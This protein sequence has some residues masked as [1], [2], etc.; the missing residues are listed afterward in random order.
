MDSRRK[1]RRNIKLTWRR[2]H[3]AVRA[4]PG[5][6][7]KGCF[8]LPESLAAALNRNANLA[9]VEM[10][11]TH[12]VGSIA[13]TLERPSR[14]S[15]RPRAFSVRPSTEDTTGSDGE[16][17]VAEIQA[18]PPV[19]VLNDDLIRH[20]VELANEA[21]YRTAESRPQCK[22][23]GT[24]TVV[25]ELDG[26]QLTLAHVG[27][28]RAYRLTN[29]SLT[30]I[31]KD[32]SL[33][34]DVIDKGYFTP[35]EAAEK[36]PGHILSRAVGVE[37]KL[38][39]EVQSFQ[40]TPGEIFL[41]CSDGLSDLVDDQLIEQSLGKNNTDLKN[42]A[43]ALVGLANEAGGRDNISVMLARILETGLESEEIW[44]SPG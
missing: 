27:D 39:V 25:A 6:E 17:T 14:R 40:V 5:V 19:E 44:S 38:E 18:P 7:W 8:P 1:G 12:G 35:E 21:V 4:P 32:H 41:F 28:S 30:L 36:V 20:A 42:A 13:Y 43:H 29:N 2:N 9:P 16:R 3:A 10:L 11:P 15:S 31:T 33:R 26:D 22:G 34:Q 24:T 37:E 23:M